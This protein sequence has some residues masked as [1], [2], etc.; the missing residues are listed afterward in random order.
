[1]FNASTP[2]A[3]DPRRSDIVQWL[4]LILALVLLSIQIVYDQWGSKER[5]EAEATSRLESQSLVVTE[6]LQRRFGS[7]Y[8]VLGKL[9]DTA[10]LHLRQSGG[11]PSVS[12]SLETL[13]LALDGV[14]TLAVF[15]AQGTILACNRPE[16]IGKNFAQR[17]YFQALQAHPDPDALYVSEPLVTVM[18]VYSMVVARR[19]SDASGVFAGIVTAAIDTQSIQELLQSMHAGAETRLSVIHAGGKLLIMVPPSSDAPPGL[20]V[21]KQGSFFQQH[22]Q[23]GRS[24]S[25]LRGSAGVLGTPRL[26]SMRTM[27]VPELHLTAPL[28]VVAGRDVDEVL[29]PW[30]AQARARALVFLAVAVLSCGALFVFQRRQRA[31]DQGIRDK[32][33]ELQRTLSMLQTFIDHLPGT[34]Y[35]KDADSRVL[36][37]NRGF[38]TFLN[39]DPGTMLGKTT[40]ELFPGAFGEQVTADDHA[41]LHQ[42]GTVVIEESLGGREFEST[43]FVMQ[44][45]TGQRWLGGMTTEITQRKQA[46]RER[47]QQLESLRELNQKLVDAEESLRRLSTAVEQSPTSIVITDLH[48]NIIFVNDAFTQTSGYTQQE[49]LGKNPR[50]LQSGHTPPETYADLWPTLISG[51]TWRGEFANKRK[52]G[53]HY[54]ELATISPVRNPAGVVTHY[55]AVKEDITE[56]CRVEAELANHRQHL[57]ELVELRT[58]ELRIAKTKADD[59]NRAKSEFLSN[60]SHEIRT[61]MNAIIGLNYLLRQSTLLPQQVDKLN[62]MSIAAEHLLKIINDILDLSKIEA[63]KLVLAHRAFSPQDMLNSIGGLVR[64]QLLAKNLRLQIDPSDMPGQVWGDETRLRQVLLNFVGNAIKFTDGGTITLSAEP[65]FNNGVEVVGRFTVHDTGIGIQSADLPRLFK[66]FEQLDGSTT[67]RYGGTGLGLA[68]ARHLAELMGGEVGVNS[69]PGQGSSFWMTAHL[70][71]T[72][73]SEPI[74]PAPRLWGN[75]TLRGRVLLVEDDPVNRDL[76]AELLARV[77]LHV[78]TANNGQQ[79]LDQYQQ[80]DFDVVLMDIQMPVLDGLEATRRIRALAHGA[81]VPVV[82]LTANVFAA[83]QAEYREAGMTDFLAKPVNPETLYALLAKY[84]PL[85]QPALG[86]PEP[87]ALDAVHP[88]ALSS[89]ELL[90]QITVLAKL[91]QSGDSRATAFFY[92]MHADLM[93]TFP[94]VCEPLQ[95]QIDQ[96]NFEAAWSTV[97]PLAE[98]PATAPTVAIE[99]PLHLEKSTQ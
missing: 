27:Q 14:R 39:M 75:A 21:S 95:R 81:A 65:V 18:G 49:A 53:S 93:R 47:Q 89:T 15:D 63:G 79:A 16:V 66:T 78:T 20:M 59:A 71:L 42:G 44:D 1:M 29:A 55:V 48:A 67:R 28:I 99:Q 98:A 94:A 84:L 64:E 90:R 60:M 54:L 8:A 12:K 74:G 46:E 70:D 62:K 58:A 23:S 13:N 33:A 97:H 24:A 91:L 37:A 77:G 22:V 69:A 57:E 72:G 35:V 92:A 6:E 82:A 96:F 85:A 83:E 80:S 38:Q 7:M 3:A 52:D 4:I 19:V 32:E 26:V 76:G 45:G 73:A 41:V 5:I 68:I 56:R 88:M 2:V 30:W 43:K 36:M 25:Q 31:F 86:P 11:A 87:L 17:D 10:P 40:K 50:L 51:K 61:P 9:R 34:A